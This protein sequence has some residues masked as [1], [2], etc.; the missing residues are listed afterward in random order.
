MTRAL[1][2]AGAGA[3]GEKWGLAEEFE[4]RTQGRK[5]GVED[6]RNGAHTGSK[7]GTNIVTR[8]RARTQIHKNT[9]LKMH[10]QAASHR[11]CLG[12]NWRDFTCSGNAQMSSEAR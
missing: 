7:T 1:T 10:T 4:I 2:H 12:G 3:G 11:S 6:G 8:E 5:V 9:N